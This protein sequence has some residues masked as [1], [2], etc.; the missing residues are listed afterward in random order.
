MACA[1]RC[2]T[3]PRDAHFSNVMALAEQSGA[4]RSEAAQAHTHK[5]ESRQVATQLVFND[6]VTSDKS[7]PRALREGFSS[8]RCTDCS[9]TLNPPVSWAGGP[10]STDEN[11]RHGEG[12]FSCL[13]S[14][15]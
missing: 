9:L 3:V 2:S 8:Q 5:G 12:S 10:I 15:N 6:S 14:Q 11:M 7:I 13:R 4:W 1:Q